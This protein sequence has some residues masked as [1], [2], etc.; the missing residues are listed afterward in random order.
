[1]KKI[2]SMKSTLNRALSINR[3]STTLNILNLSSLNPLLFNKIA[4]EVNK[5]CLRP[6]EELTNQ[7]TLKLKEGL[8]YPQNLK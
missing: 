1:M 8:I 5:W 7:Q 6:K 4:R 3:A 2:K